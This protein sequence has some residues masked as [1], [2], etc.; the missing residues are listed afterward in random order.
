MR[1]VAVYAGTRNVYGKMAVAARSLLANNRMDRVYFLIEDE[2]FP[3]RL[4]EVIR[5]IDM[6]GQEIFPL[7]GPNT[8]TIWTY[9]ALL[10]CALTRILP[11]EKRVLWLDVDTIVDG[12]IT[13][14]L[15]TDLKGKCLAG[16]RENAKSIG[17]VYINA[18][19]LLMDL[20]QLR[21]TGKDE[22]LIRL[23]N[24]ERL[25]FPD[26]D[27]I[28]RLCC[29]EIV[30]VGNEWNS[31]W[32]TGMNRWPCIMHYAAL[33]DYQTDALWRKYKVMDWPAFL[34]DT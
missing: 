12:D 4:P 21:R 26:Q 8:K 20:E 15:E 5:C 24:S 1:K 27:A 19:V 13:E 7:D 31:N 30:E 29:D 2:A 18:G 14:L 32:F 25:D 28:N 17:T 34:F 6:S 3:E 33:S 22:E 11:E 9:M 23:L 10:R 16:V